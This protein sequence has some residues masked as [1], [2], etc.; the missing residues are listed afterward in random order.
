VIKGQEAE[1]YNRRRNPYEG[2]AARLRE[3]YE[4]ESSEGGNLPLYAELVSAG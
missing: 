3:A 1:C 2:A 4:N